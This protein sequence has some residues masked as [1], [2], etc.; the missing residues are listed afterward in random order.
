M[1]T[2]HSILLPASCMNGNNTHKAPSTAVFLNQRSAKHERSFARN[3]GMHKH[4]K[5]LKYHI[6]FHV[7]P[8]NCHRMCAQKL[9]I[10]EYSPCTT[11]FFFS[12]L[13]KPFTQVGVPPWKKGWK[14]LLYRTW[15]CT[16]MHWQLCMKTI[17]ILAMLFIWTDWFCKDNE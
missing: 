11:L 10:M 6:K 1:L 3:H 5:I 15:Y 12:P 7:S 2:W 16:L 14:T 17:A 13:C 9:A 8:F 4:I